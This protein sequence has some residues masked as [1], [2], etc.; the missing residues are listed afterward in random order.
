MSG[1]WEI[2]DLAL[3]IANRLPPPYDTTPT[4]K[5]RVGAV[6]TVNSVRWSTGHQCVALGL[7][8]AR[9]KGLLGGWH[10]CVFRKITPLAQDEFDRETIALLNGRPV[11][12]EA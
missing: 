6:Y 8:E 9:S 1:G 2:G 12:V 11:H 3:C 10:A 7:N 5:L 4:K